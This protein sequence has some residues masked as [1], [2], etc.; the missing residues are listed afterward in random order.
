[1]REGLSKASG[2]SRRKDNLTDTTHWTMGD[3]NTWGQVLKTLRDEIEQINESRRD[4]Y[5]TLCGLESNMLR[6]QPFF[7]SIQYGY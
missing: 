3:I 5:Q 4:I 6:G 2:L 1:M 7:I